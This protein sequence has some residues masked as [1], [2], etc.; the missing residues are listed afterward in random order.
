ME[1]QRKL[2]GYVD[3]G[4]ILLVVYS[5]F[6]EGMVSG[7]WQQIGLSDIVVLLVVNAALLGAML[8]LTT[9]AARKLGF[10]KAD[11]ITIVFC[12]STKSLAEIGRASCRE[13]VCQY[14]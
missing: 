12:G 5:A 9:L 1:R 6:S 13:R 2:L 8:G 3:R 14:E 4:S 11:E 7:M 10:H